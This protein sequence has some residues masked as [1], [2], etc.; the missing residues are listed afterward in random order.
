M[1]RFGFFFKLI[2]IK[3]LSIFRIFAIIAIESMAEPKNHGI[4]HITNFMH[5]VYARIVISINIIRFLNF[6]EILF[7]N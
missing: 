6:F 5:M 2:S 4:A 1:L 7:I 3:K